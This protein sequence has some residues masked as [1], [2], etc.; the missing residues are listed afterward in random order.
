MDT[1]KSKASIMIKHSDCGEVQLL[2]AY[3]CPY[4][5]TRLRYEPSKYQISILEWRLARRSLDGKVLQGSEPKSA[6]KFKIHAS[7]FAA[8]VPAINLASV[9]DGAVKP[10]F[11]EAQDMQDPLEKE[12]P[13][14]ASK[15]PS[16]DDGRKCSLG[17][18]G[19]GVLP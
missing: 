6:R 3:H 9:I 16:N 15:Y 13:V 17:R 18:R 11:L 12:P 4:P 10:C 8:S 19:K 1:P 14:L 5:I 2:T 7:S